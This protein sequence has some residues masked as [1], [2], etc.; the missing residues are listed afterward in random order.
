MPSTVGP[1]P[2][3]GIVWHAM[4]STTSFKTKN[5]ISRQWRLCGD[6][7]Q[8]RAGAC[9]LLSLES[10]IMNCEVLP[11]LT[12]I[13]GWEDFVSFDGTYT[14][15]NDLYRFEPT[16]FLSFLSGRIE[17]VPFAIYQARTR[18]RF[19]LNAL[20]ETYLLPLREHFKSELLDLSL[21]HI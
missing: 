4:S 16:P 8:R 1:S 13:P 6:H 7:A 3:R 5:E 20:S 17:A 21:I 15:Q 14:T 18:R 9:D 19:T 2:L 12:Q 10:H 11:T